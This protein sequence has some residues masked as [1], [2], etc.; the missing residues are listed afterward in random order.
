MTNGAHTATR[1]ARYSIRCLLFVAAFVAL[2]CAGSLGS[3]VAFAQT[4]SAQDAVSLSVKPLSTPPPGAADIGDAVLLLPAAVDS[5]LEITSALDGPTVPNQVWSLELVEGDEVWIGIGYPAGA[6]FRA[7]LWGPT[8]TSV[9]AG[10]PHIDRASELYPDIEGI[11]YYV[12]Q[13]GSGTYYLDVSALS[14][15]GSYT[16]RISPERNSAL[17]RIS[18]PDRYRTATAISKS[19]WVAADSVVLATGAGYADALAA[20]ALAG[21]LECPILLAPPYSV[22]TGAGSDYMVAVADEI[23]RLGANTVYIVGEADVVPRDVETF[24]TK[25]LGSLT[26][27]R[28]AGRTRYHTAVRVAEEVVAQ[29]P[30]VPDTVFLVRGNDFADAL[31]VAPFAFAKKYPVLLTG[32]DTLDPVA[33]AFIE[34][35]DIKTVIIAGGSAAVSDSVK[36]EVNGLNGGATTVVR[37]YGANRYETAVAVAEH[38]VGRGWLDWDTASVASGENFPDALAGGPMAGAYGGPLL[39]TKMS[40]LA[41]PSRAV[42]AEHDPSIVHIFGGSSVIEQRVWAIINQLQHGGS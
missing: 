15:S 41:M 34:A 2:T 42:L 16:L 27:K 3:D 31:A 30:V 20:S 22:A 6:D 5:Y 14:D 29:T 7:T 18:G 19:T 28:I 11:S 9:W 10:E 1:S 38:G 33:R 25:R 12:P 36:S 8:T 39:L 40:D 37:R 24:L 13:G 23:Y 32:T 21:A 35:H 26:F 17:P 4:I